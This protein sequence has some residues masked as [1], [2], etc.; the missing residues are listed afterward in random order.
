MNK[1]SGSIYE[2]SILFY[3]IL[4]RFLRLS[5]HLSP[6]SVL[7]SMCVCVCVVI[8]VDINEINPNKHF[9]EYDTQQ[10]HAKEII[11][12]MPCSNRRSFS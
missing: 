4:S 10:W 8:L 11:A 3:S 5:S 12:N 9:Y 6:C 2:N 1:T 7:M